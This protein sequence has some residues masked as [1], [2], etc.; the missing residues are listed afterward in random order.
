LLLDFLLVTRVRDTEGLVLRGEDVDSGAG[1]FFV[2]LEPGAEQV[3]V[4]F[5]ARF[6][7]CEEAVFHMGEDAGVEAEE[8]HTD[9]FFA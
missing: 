4:F 3:F 9:V 8:V 7:E 2:V 5:V 6:E 1:V